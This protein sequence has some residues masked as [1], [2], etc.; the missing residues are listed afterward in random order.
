MDSA[1]VEINENNYCDQKPITMEFSFEEHDFLNDIF[2]HMIG[3]YDITFY[4]V[5]ALPDDS[6]IKKRYNMLMSMKERSNHL[7]FVRFGNPPYNN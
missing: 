3:V 6:L 4:E 2:N 1:L 5:D 7:W